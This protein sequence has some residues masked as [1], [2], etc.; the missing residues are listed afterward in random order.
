MTLNIHNNSIFFAYGDR[1]VRASEQHTRY[2]VDVLGIQLE[3]QDDYRIFLHDG[4]LW[5]AT[6]NVAQAIAEV[7][8]NDLE[9]IC[10]LYWRY[11]F[12]E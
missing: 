5:T 9:E 11:Q 2:I 4:A 3:E 12:Y 1:E 7:S 6:T 8:E 10:R